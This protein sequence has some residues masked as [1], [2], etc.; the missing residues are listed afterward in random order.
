MSK[1]L[2][3]IIKYEKDAPEVGLRFVAEARRGVTFITEN[4]YAAA[5][6]G[7]GIRRKVLNHFPYSLCTLL[8]PSRFLP[9]FRRGGRLFAWRAF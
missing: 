5:A 4:P 7:S 9:A 1:K 2:Q 8:S 6:V 3:E